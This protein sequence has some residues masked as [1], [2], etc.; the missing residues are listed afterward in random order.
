D[1]WLEAGIGKL[2]DT[3]SGMK[4]RTL[5]ALTL[6]FDCCLRMVAAD[7]NGPKTDTYK[8]YAQDVVKKLKTFSKPYP[9]GRPDLFRA[10]GDLAMLAGQTRKAR[11]AWTQAVDAANA[12]Q[13]PLAGLIARERLA[14][15]EPAQAAQNSRPALLTAALEAARVPPPEIAP[16]ILSSDQVT[17]PIPGLQFS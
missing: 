12:L 7:P 8:G 9:I 10:Q 1:A 3:T 16:E 17:P 15:S 14:V 13:M 11:E 5:P 4:S 6:A 2:K